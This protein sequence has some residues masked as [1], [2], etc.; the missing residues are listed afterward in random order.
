MSNE[1]QRRA[2]INGGDKCGKLLSHLLRIR[3][4]RKPSDVHRVPK[5][6][7]HEHLCRLCIDAAYQNKVIVQELWKELQCIGM[8]AAGA[9]ILHDFSF[10]HEGI[11]PWVKTLFQAD[12]NA[13]QEVTCSRYNK[14]IV[15]VSGLLRTLRGAAK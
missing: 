10:N 9:S 5:E 14:K 6:I 13:S 15:G 7:V 3:G 11:R 2:A 8:I 12:R 1:T 4:I